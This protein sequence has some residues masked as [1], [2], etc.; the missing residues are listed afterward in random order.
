MEYVVKRWNKK[1]N[2]KFEH[3]EERQN[4]REKV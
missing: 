1:R 2:K 3:Y 4:W